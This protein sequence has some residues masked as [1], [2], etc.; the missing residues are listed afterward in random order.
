MVSRIQALAPATTLGSLALRSKALDRTRSIEAAITLDTLA[1]QA[2][3]L[4]EGESKW[5][6]SPQSYNYADSP[7]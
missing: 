6:D 7:L 1:R 3:L 5:M 2:T 4:K